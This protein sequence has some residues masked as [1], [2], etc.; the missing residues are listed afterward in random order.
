MEISEV[1]EAIGA[2]GWTP[3]ML[4][5][6]EQLLA[7]QAVSEAVRDAGKVAQAVQAAIAGSDR[8]AGKPKLAAYMQAK[9]APDYAALREAGPE[10]VQAAIDELIDAELES[11]K[12]LGVGVMETGAKLD[13]AGSNPAGDSEDDPWHNFKP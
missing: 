9:L 5:S 8:L 12:R 7:D 10:A 1:L 3:R 6:R 4:F 13:M 11:M 2:N